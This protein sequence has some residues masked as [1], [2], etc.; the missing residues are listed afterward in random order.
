MNLDG[1]ISSQIWEVLSHYCF[2]KLPAPFPFSSPSGTAIIHRL[3]LLMLSHSSHRLSL[4]FFHFFK[5]VLL[6]FGY[7]NEVSPKFN[8]FLTPYGHGE[9]I[10]PLN[11]YF[12]LIIHIWKSSTEGDWNECAFWQATFT[13][14]GHSLVCLLNKPYF[15]ARKLMMSF[16]GLLG[17]KNL[18]M[19]R[20]RNFWLEYL[21]AHQLRLSSPKG[22]KRKAREPH[23]L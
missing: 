13:M 5:F 21:Q 16:L 4:L 2:N 12:H 7:L 11:I 6:R 23:M 18:R 19:G 20:P 15:G 8:F 9:K 17:N 22:W 1:Q 3:L 10:I 14:A